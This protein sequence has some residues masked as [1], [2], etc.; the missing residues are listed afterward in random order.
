MSLIPPESAKEMIKDQNIFHK[1]LIDHYSEII[2][3][4]FVFFYCT[5]DPQLNPF[6]L[7]AS[8]ENHDQGTEHI[9]NLLDQ[10]N[11]ILIENVFEMIG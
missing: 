1:Y 5:I 8:F 9:V 3:S 7:H 6:L 11:S 10:I 2:S 4:P